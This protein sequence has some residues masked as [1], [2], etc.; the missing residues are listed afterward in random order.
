MKWW[1]LTVPANPLPIVVPD[2]L[3]FCPTSNESTLIFWDT[4][5]ESVEGTLYSFKYFKGGKL[6][7]AKCH[8]RGLVIFWGEDSA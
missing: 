5:K 3:T 7:L 4:V 8:K 2:M 6:D 1:R